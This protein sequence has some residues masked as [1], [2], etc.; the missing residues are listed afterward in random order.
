M[1]LINMFVTFNKIIIQCKKMFPVVSTFLEMYKLH[2]EYLTMY[3]IKNSE[4]VIQKNVH[5]VFEKFPACI[6]LC[7]TCALEIYNGIEKKQTCVKKQKHLKQAEKKKKSKNTKKIKKE[8][9]ENQK[10]NEERKNKKQ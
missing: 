4:H 2:L 7:F 10:Y 8:T 1:C 9:K 3:S 5:H 6:K